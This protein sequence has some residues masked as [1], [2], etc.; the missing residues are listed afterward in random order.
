ME[1]WK[2]SKL[3]IANKTNTNMKYKTIPEIVITGHEGLGKTVGL[4]KETIDEID[5][6]IERSLYH[7]GKLSSPLAMANFIRSVI[8]SPS[9]SGGYRLPPYEKFAVIYLNR[10]NQVIGVH[11]LSKGGVSGTVVDPVIIFAVALKLLASS[12]VISHNHPSGSMRPSDADIKISVK[13]VEIGKIHGINLLDHLILSDDDFYS[14]ANEQTIPLS[15][16]PENVTIK[17]NTTDM[18]TKENIRDRAAGIDQSKFPAD[19]IEDDWSTV[20]GLTSNFTDYSPVDDD[21]KLSE[22][23]DIVFGMAIDFLKD[24]EV[25]APKPAAAPEKQAKVKKQRVKKEKA[26]KVEKEKVV[27]V[28]K[29]KQ[30][31][32]EKIDM[33][34]GVFELDPEI[35]F[36]RRYVNLD[37]R[38]LHKEDIL[39][40]LV[41]LQRAIRLQ[42]IRKTS[43]YA[44][45]IIY[46]QNELLKIWNKYHGGN[47]SFV[48]NLDRKDSALANLASLG[49]S[50]KIMDAVAAVK[51]FLSIEGKSDVKDKA[52]KLFVRFKAM[53]VLDIREEYKAV[54]PKVIEDIKKSLGDYID[55]KTDTVEIPEQALNGLSGLGLLDYNDNVKAGDLVRAFDG[56]KGKVVAVHSNSVEI[57]SNPGH[58]YA[59]KKVK[60]LEAKPC[61]GVNCLNGLD[62]GQIMSSTDFVNMQ[63]HPVGFT[64]KWLQLIGDPVEPWKMMTWS[65]PGKGKSTLM[66]ELAKYLAET[67]G[68]TVLFVAKEEGFNSTLKDKFIRLNATDPLISISS[69]LPTNLSDYNYVFI[70]SVTA[71]KLSV[72]DLSALIKKYPSTSFVFI[73]QSTVD[74]GYRGNKEVEHLVDVSIYINES[75]YASA[76]KTRFGGS[77]T[78]NVFPGQD[79]SP[80]YKFT[81][82]QDA[83][84]FIG[85]E[86]NA[87]LSLV[88]GDDGRYWATTSSKASKLR[89]GGFEVL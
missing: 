6:S 10:A 84:K 18:I 71:F 86:E 72:D 59:K 61:N 1:F 46:V 39:R 81:L 7:D 62:D 75:G 83:E 37:G 52:L 57:D 74:G 82:L 49:S 44:K 4:Y 12:I 31:K 9:P 35:K 79:N 43:K 85:K 70:D 28:K 78:I 63:F 56:K 87:G 26:V 50:F 80:I 60:V 33:R 36:I 47:A 15:G 3:N 42:K 20:S 73:Y 14:F 55:G 69:E 76:Q 41:P 11:Q 2:F 32:P 25:P 29:E 34:E 13:I 24:K 38:T 48:F 67:H 45:E 21:E 17:N 19:F 54:Y 89:Q 16:I 27:K 64:G 65:K 53:D 77:G 51:Q 5:I 40:I 23:V 68:R 66:I 30:P 8:G 22:Y 58:Y 88:V